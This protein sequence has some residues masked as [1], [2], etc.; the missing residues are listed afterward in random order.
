MA[1]G[2]LL[3]GAA[4]SANPLLAIPSLAAMA[5]KGGAELSTKRAVS[6]LGSM[7]RNGGP[8]PKKQTSQDEK[9]AMISSLLAQTAAQPQ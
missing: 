1:G 2:G 7:I 4:S 3:A 6:D 5:A 9:R 8:M